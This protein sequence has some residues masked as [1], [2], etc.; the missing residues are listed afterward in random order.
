MIKWLQ[1]S[2]KENNF[3]IEEVVTADHYHSFD[4]KASFYLTDLKSGSIK[5]NLIFER[6]SYVLSHK[7]KKHATQISEDSTWTSYTYLK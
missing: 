7:E 3:E 4:F 5:I 1:Y 2:I 6:P